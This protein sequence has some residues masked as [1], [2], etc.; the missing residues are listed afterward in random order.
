MSRN[1]PF[2]LSYI[3]L[4]TYSVYLCQT[5]GTKVV[6]LTN[7]ST[8][9]VIDGTKFVFVFFYASWDEQSTKI[10]GTYGD[11]AD[12]FKHRKDIIIAKANGYEDTKLAIR[13]WIDRFPSFRF[14]IKG[15]KTEET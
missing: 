7:A 3:F 5:S 8:D 6:E 14:F 1:F 15:S 9:K 13:F 4:V 12:A 10:M 2:H 11:V